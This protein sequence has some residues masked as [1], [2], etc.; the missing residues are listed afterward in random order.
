MIRNKEW[1]LNNPEKVKDIKHNHRIRNR[2]IITKYTQEY[3]KANPDKYSAHKIM[4]NAIRRGELEQKPCEVCGNIKSQGHHEDYSKP[5]EIIW[6]CA[7]HHNEA[8]KKTKS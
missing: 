4:K 5:L 1:V 2:S 3:R 8:H 7:K 6:L